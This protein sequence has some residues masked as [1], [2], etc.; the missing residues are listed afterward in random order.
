MQY[1]TRSSQASIP[2]IYTSTASNF[3]QRARQ[4]IRSSS[5]KCTTSSDMDFDDSF[6]P[7]LQDSI[8][9][10]QTSLILPQTSNILR[11]A[12]TESLYEPVPDPIN[13]EK[14]ESAQFDIPSTFLLRSSIP[15]TQTPRRPSPTSTASLDSSITSIST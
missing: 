3:T 9:S 13:L 8:Y 1:S 2:S 15:S 7:S 10:M 5:Y 11:C 12:L 14:K 6:N 4:T